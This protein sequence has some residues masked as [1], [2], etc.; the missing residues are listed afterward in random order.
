ME[1]AL[2]AADLF[3]M[4][5]K[6]AVLN[7]WEVGII[8]FSNNELIITTDPISIPS[9]PTTPAVIGGFV[10]YTTLSGSTYTLNRVDTRQ[11]ASLNDIRSIALSS[12][13][14]NT[15]YPSKIAIAVYN[16]PIIVYSIADNNTSYNNTNVKTSSNI[17][18]W[19]SVSI[20]STNNQRIVACSSFFGET[21]NPLGPND[22]RIL[23]S[24]NGGDDWGIIT[25][26]KKYGTSAQFTQFTQEELNKMDITNANYDRFFNGYNYT[27]V[28]FS[29]DTQIIASY[30]F[31]Q[32]YSLS[33]NVWITTTTNENINGSG[34]LG[35]TLPN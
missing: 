15:N 3:N 8:N 23:Y 35:I 16:G 28:D 13:L 18:K 11:N 27:S 33:A 14:S 7:G 26:P 6:V 1:A 10:Y 4:Y 19:I 5:Q 32:T 29:T 25:N 17:G 30:R 12:T 2:F 20:S 31:A 22:G 34:L 9:T 24:P 21:I